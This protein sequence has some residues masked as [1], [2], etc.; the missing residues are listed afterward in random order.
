MDRLILTDS[1]W[2]KMEPH[3]LGKSIDTGRS[4]K[5]NRL[6]LEAIL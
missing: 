3:R 4:G 6:F 2:A 1:Q 5:D